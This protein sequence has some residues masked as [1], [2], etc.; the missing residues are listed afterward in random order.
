MYMGFEIAKDA[1]DGLIGKPP[2]MEEVETIKH[3]VMDVPGVLGAHDIIVHSYGQDKFVS[4][5]VEI[6][7]KE[8]T[9]TAHDISEDVDTEFVLLSTPPSFYS[10]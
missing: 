9:A 8:T 6:D 5:H 4:V 1:V 2:T 7:A 10:A 3:I